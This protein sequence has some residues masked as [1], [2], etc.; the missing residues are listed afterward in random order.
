MPLHFP[1]GLVL[2]NG[3]GHHVGYRSFELPNAA[4]N[5]LPWGLRVAGEELHNNHHAFPARRFAHRLPTYV[6]GGR[7]A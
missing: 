1:Y 3:L 4:T 6:P 5:F 7:S 2:V